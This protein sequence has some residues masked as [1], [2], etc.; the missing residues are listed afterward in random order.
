MTAEQERQAAVVE[1]ALQQSVS[2]T[3]TRLQDR[4][5]RQQER[6]AAGGTD[7][8]IAI[9]TTNDEID[10]LTASLQQRR[11]ALARRRVTAIDT[12]RVVGV[13]DV[14]PGPVPAAWGQAGGDRTAVELAAMNV[15]M[16]DERQANR[17]PIDVSKTGVG[18]DIRSSAPDGSVRYIEVKGHVTTGDVTLY[19]TEWQTAHRMRE[20]FFIY[21]VDHALSAPSLWMVQDPVGKGVEPTEKVVEYHV[22]E[23]QLQAAASGA[24]PPGPPSEKG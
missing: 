19:Y 21:V 5:E 2:D 15:V 12:P 24:I 10:L 18:Y 14:I 11:A 8:R 9:R 13:A 20:E 22:T 16:E 7:M 3:L 23:A 1:R 4:L 17:E 6:A